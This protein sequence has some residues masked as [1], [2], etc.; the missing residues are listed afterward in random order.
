[1]RAV[2]VGLLL[3]AAWSVAAADV[4][5]QTSVDGAIRGNVKDDQG[6]VLP[7]VAITA[8][9]ATVAGAHTTV[10]D[11]EGVY[12]LTELPP[13]E[14]TITAELQGFSKFVRSGVLVRAGLN[15]ALDIGMKLG[16]FSETVQVTADTPML[17]VEKPVQAVNIE[18][19]LQR[20]LPL[21]PRRDYTDFLEVTPGLNTYTNPQSGGG[22]YALRGSTIESHVVQVDGADMTSFRQSRPDYIALSTDSLVDVQVKTA[23]SDASAPLGEGVVISIA[24]P[25]G[26]NQIKGSGS[27]AFTPD[28]WNANN[29]PNGQSNTSSLFQQDVSLGGPILRD[30][31]WFFG[32]FR[33]VRRDIGINRSTSQL[34]LD[35]ALVP[36]WTSFPNAFKGDSVFLKTTVH[37]SSKHQV[38]GFYQYD[39]YPTETNTSADNRNVEVQDYGGAGVSARLSSAWNATTTTRIGIAFNNKALNSNASA[40]DGHQTIGPSMPVHLGVFTS[41]GHLVGTGALLQLNGIETGSVTPGSKPTISGDLTYYKSGWAGS[42]ELQT[43]VYLQ[44][45]ERADS[46]TLYSNDGFALQEV[47]LRDP[48]NPAAGFVPFHKRVYDVASAVTTSVSAYDNAVYVQDAWKPIDRLTVNAGLRVDFVKV[49]DLQANI[50]TEDSKNI[51]PR[52]GAA[53]VLT[54]DRLNVLRASWGRVHELVQSN[55]VPTLGSNTPGFTDYYDNRLDGSFGTVLRTP[56]NSTKSS[57]RVLDPNDHRPYIDEWTAGYRRQLPG[58]MSVDGGFVHR[59]YRDRPAL[60]DT[61]GIYNGNVFGGYQNPAFN[62]IFLVTNDTYNWYVYNGLEFLVTKRTRHV[63]M[64]ASYV[65]A[66]RHID[67]TWQ[68]HDPASF[69]QPAAFPNDKCLGIPRTAPSNSLSGTADTFGCTGWQNH[70][71]RLAVNYN[72]P[73]NLLTAVNFTI[74]SGPY[75]GPIITKIAAPDP[76]FG[77]PTL[78]LSNGRL[79]ANPLATTLRLAGPT[80]SDGQVKAPARAE[81]DLHIGRKFIV[82]GD[83]RFEAALDFFNVTNRGA[84]E[85]FLSDA[86]Q[87]FNPDYL[88]GQN[89][90]PP[91]TAQVTVRFTF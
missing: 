45:H 23:A 15:L 91:R 59:E 85:R 9:S 58:A 90:Q 67:G 87:P 70:T 30:R 29:N 74:Q 4:L 6:A 46:T 64:M 72:A 19:A 65:R 78:L 89:I 26:T 61:N 63:Q 49:R 86:N 69:I 2:F 14:Y 56:G 42:H 12:R 60:V 71:G 38:E 28:R 77:P 3:V 41:S 40:Y 16:T 10:S 43:G 75:T 47:V 52:F 83:R 48:M 31:A 54:N 66:W 82:G 50:V 32:S 1:M 27:L 21:T 36:G 51:G 20:E 5:G 53:Y 44:P 35:R 68:P 8:T 34:A 24:S 13:G 79:V 80:R 25:T 18:G 76:Q 22:I 7:G 11:K 84:I 33:N 81:L 62:E 55:N 39:N 37:A 73:W 17:E 57:N 88:Q